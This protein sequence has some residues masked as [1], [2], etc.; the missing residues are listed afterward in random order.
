M[1][2]GVSMAVEGGG[3]VGKGKEKGKRGVEEGREK[4]EAGGRTQWALFRASRAQQTMFSRG[5]L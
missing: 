2:K 5:C 3:G 4:E 1:R